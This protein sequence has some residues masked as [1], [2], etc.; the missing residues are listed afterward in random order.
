MDSQV[1]ETE[2]RTQEGWQGFPEM[3]VE[4][5]DMGKPF[6]SSIIRNIMINLGMPFLPDMPPQPQVTLWRERAGGHS[7]ISDHIKWSLLS[8][9]GSS[10][11]FFTKKISRTLLDIVNKS[12]FP[13]KLKKCYQMEG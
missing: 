8:V 1:L 6:F 11:L 9:L 7:W 10:L 13:K 5:R 12:F 3:M 4:M 2:P